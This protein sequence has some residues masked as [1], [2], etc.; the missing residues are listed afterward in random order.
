M[1][2]SMSSNTSRRIAGSTQLTKI[3]SFRTHVREIRYLL[4]DID[5]RIVVLPHIQ[6]PAWRGDD[7]RLEEQDALAGRAPLIVT[8]SAHRPRIGTAQK[9][10]SLPFIGSH[11]PD[12]AR[13]SRKRTALNLGGRLHGPESP[14]FQCLG[15]L[16]FE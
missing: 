7:M 1:T 5:N 16:V 15:E 6:L 12:L 2:D 11:N 9:Q 10:P 8:T 4:V 3:G 13:W 14:E